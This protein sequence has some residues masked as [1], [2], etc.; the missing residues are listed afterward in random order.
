M[1]PDEGPQDSP[2]QWLTRA[3]GHLALARYPKPAD[4][5]WEDLA[6]HAQQAAELAIKAVYQHNEL[7]FPWAHRIDELA[8]TLD[9]AGVA[10]PEAV[11]DA[12]ALTR[13]AVLT[14]YPGLSRPVTQEE[15]EGAV[16][17]AQ[18]VLDWAE[19]IIIGRKPEP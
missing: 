14:R 18:G 13:Y 8:K 10:I 6:L 19:S 17:L 1:Q 5:F 3:A 9:E 2:A 11:K 4:G 15:H 12:V 16:R 7:T